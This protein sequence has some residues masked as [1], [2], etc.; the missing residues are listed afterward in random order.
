MIRVAN[1]MH[2][3]PYIV[4]KFTLGFLVTLVTIAS[5]H[6]EITTIKGALDVVLK[7]KAIAEAGEKMKLYSLAVNYNGKTK[8]WSFQFYDGGA[9]LHGITIDQSGKTRYYPRDKGTLRV[10]DHIDFS[11][12][13]AP[14]DV[15]IHNIIDQGKA[16]LKQLN[17]HPV[18]NGKIY[19]K[20]YVRHETLQQ[21]KAYHSWS[22][23]MPTSG[24]MGDGL[25]KEKGKVN[26]RLQ[27]KT[28]TFK[29]GK[30]D[31]VTNAI[32]YGG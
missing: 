7:Q 29:N 26:N 30:V 8:R 6:A 25:N 1:A 19:I 13:P 3:L 12:L 4:K 23:T 2:K 14:H 18:R 5:I 20:Y 24:G 21:D 32:V 16:T 10:F 15:L 11:K 22:I 28:V 17:F 31:T 9:K 27:G